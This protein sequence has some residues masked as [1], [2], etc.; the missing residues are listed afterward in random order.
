VLVLVVV[1]VLEAV[2]YFAGN[3]YIDGRR[4]YNPSIA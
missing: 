3:T 1:L 2:V 4:Q